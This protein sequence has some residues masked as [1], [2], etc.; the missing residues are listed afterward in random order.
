MIAIEERLHFLAAGPLKLGWSERGSLSIRSQRIVQLKK[1]AI[2]ARCHGF[3]VV[4]LSVDNDNLLMGSVP[5]EVFSEYAVGLCLNL[6]TLRPRNV[7]TLEVRAPRRPPAPHWSAWRERLGARPP[8]RRGL[9]FQP[10]RPRWLPAPRPEPF[11]F[12]LVGEPV[13]G[14]P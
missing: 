6:P 11:H 13:R 10:K 14:R 12:A 1:L 7:F 4:A 3:D 5:A 8:V 9:W 2:P